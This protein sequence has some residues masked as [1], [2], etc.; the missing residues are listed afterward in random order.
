MNR[1]QED[2]ML[3]YKNYEDFFKDWCDRSFIVLGEVTQTG[4]IEIHRT[5]ELFI[6]GNRPEVGEDCI[7]NMM[8]LHQDVW[9]FV[10]DFYGRHISLNSNSYYHDLGAFTSKIPHYWFSVRDRV[11][12]YL[13]RVYFFAAES[14]AIH[15]AYAS[16]Y[17]M[18]VKLINNFIREVEIITKMAQ[19]HMINMKEVKK[20]F[21]IDVSVY[22][23]TSIE[24]LNAVLKKRGKLN[25]GEQITPRE[26]LC[27]DLYCQGKNT[28]QTARELDISKRTVETYFNRMKEKLNVSSKSE[29]LEII[30]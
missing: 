27:L 6:C 14:P 28:M 1:W 13:Q 8:W 12:D 20:D 21:L 15:S 19:D 5:G 7:E 17:A 4:V 10:N 30:T 22:N 24:K 2:F 3:G 9:A 25:T 18:V 11:N 23:K 16:N 26:W 29:I